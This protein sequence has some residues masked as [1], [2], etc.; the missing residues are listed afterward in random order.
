MSDF[1]V[2]SFKV[3]DKVSTRLNGS[4]GRGVS[5]LVSRGGHCHKLVIASSNAEVVSECLLFRLDDR[6]SFTWTLLFK[7]CLLS[8]VEVGIG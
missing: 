4:G 7:E 2:I 3:L 6:L 8:G 1:E 5:E